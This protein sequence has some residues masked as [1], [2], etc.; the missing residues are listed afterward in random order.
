[1]LQV[2]TR[3]P[4]DIHGVCNPQASSEL[5]LLSISAAAIYGDLFMFCSGREVRVL[6]FKRFRFSGLDAERGPLMHCEHAAE[7]KEARV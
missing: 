5:I 7:Q 6:M 3:Y 4:H 1:M 2:A